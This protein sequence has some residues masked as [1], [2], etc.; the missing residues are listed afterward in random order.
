METVRLQCLI[1]ARQDTSTVYTCL[2]SVLFLT[3]IEFQP[4]DDND[5]TYIIDEYPV[6]IGEMGLSRKCAIAY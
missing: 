3:N 5:G 4:D 2:S 1:P 6:N